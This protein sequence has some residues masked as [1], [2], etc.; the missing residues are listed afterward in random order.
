[1]PGLAADS[2]L[3]FPAET[4]VVVVVVPIYP[5]IVRPFVASTVL[6]IVVVMP[7]AVGLAVIKTPS[8]RSA[9]SQR[10]ASDRRTERLARGL[11]RRDHRA[12]AQ[13]SG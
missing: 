10:A 1:M 4:F 12:C 8:L 5:E 6:A 7:D 3:A 11:V 13:R 2:V 9:E